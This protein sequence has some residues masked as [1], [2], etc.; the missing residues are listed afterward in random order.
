MR[1]FYISPLRYPGGKAALA[2]FF[3]EVM[4]SQTS[5]PKTFVEPFAGGAGAAL[6]LLYTGRADRLVINDA[7]PGIAAFWRCVFEHTSELIEEIKRCEL[8]I[9][10]WHH[11]RAVYQNTSS[12]DLD[13]GFA[14][15]YLNRTNRSGILEA[16]PIGGLQQSGKWKIDARFNRTDLIERIRILGQYRDQVRVEQ[17]D[18]LDLLESIPTRDTFFYVDPPY[19]GQ[20]DELY[21]NTLTWTDHLRLAQILRRRHRRWVVT[22]DADPR[23]TSTLYRG[24]RCAEFS[25]KHTAAKQQIGTEYAVFSSKLVVDK[26][27]LLSRGFATWL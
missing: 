12:S 14:T 15:L 26:L 10:A 18:A 8:S 5:R 25:I 24:M 16:R 20:G 11:Y 2:D 4:A 21:L 19:L 6:R 17:Q 3:G 22:Y 9:D 23:I 1:Y 13:L 7:H 27:D